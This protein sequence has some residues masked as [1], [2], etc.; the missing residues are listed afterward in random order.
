MRMSTRAAGL[1][2]KVK[3]RNPLHNSPIKNQTLPHHKLIKKSKLLQKIHKMIRHENRTV[4]RNIKK[5]TGKTR[6][7]EGISVSLNP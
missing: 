2:L 4:E 5:G 6:A 3:E 7:W 1:Q